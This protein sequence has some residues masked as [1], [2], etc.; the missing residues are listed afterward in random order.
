MD[1]T[2]LDQ[3]SRALR[4]LISAQTATD[5]AALE[6]RQLLG[7]VLERNGR[8]VKDAAA[9]AALEDRR[10]RMIRQLERGAEVML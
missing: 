7:Q 9:A 1:R 2:D 5:A 10:A 4:L 6:A 3:I 8:T